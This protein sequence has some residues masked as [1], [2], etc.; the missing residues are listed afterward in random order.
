MLLWRLFPLQF[1]L[2]P[3]VS[4]LD[5]QGSPSPNGGE[6]YPAYVAVEVGRSYSIDTSG[7]GA[8]AASS[9]LPS[10]VAQIDLHQG[11][12]VFQIR[13]LRPGFAQW[14][15]ATGRHPVW[16]AVLREPRA[17]PILVGHRGVPS[18]A[19]ENTLA[20]VEVACGLGLPGIEVDVRFT[21][22][23]VP[24]LMHDRDVARTTGGHGNV[25]QLT[26]A[27][28]AALDAGSWFGSDFAGEPVPTLEE[29]LAAAA[30]CG[31][32]RIELDVKDFVPAGVD[33]G[34]TRIA[35]EARSI[36]LVPRVLFGADFASLQRAAVLIPDFHTLVYGGVITDS[37]AN[38]LILARVSA[39]SVRFDQYLQSMEALARL[40][41]AGVLLAVWSPPSVLDLNALTPVPKAVTAD[42]AWSFDK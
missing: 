5:P 22:D 12:S 36:G 42:W 38:A 14:N 28:L 25:D 37:Y 15:P 2:L 19:P 8:R 26:L 23:S 21:A 11:D 27:E 40:D 7:P 16:I 34:T 17:G 30:R 32:D 24:V 20:G 31:F 18:L 3:T 39:V 4:C 1:L 13:G 33:S 10:D 35:R 29:F 41:S 9:A 6:Y